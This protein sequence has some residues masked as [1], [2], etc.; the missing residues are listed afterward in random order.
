MEVKRQHI[1]FIIILFFILGCGGSDKPT[2]PEQ[3]SP[4]V[5]YTPGQHYGDVLGYID[6]L[7][8]NTP[9]IITVP[10]DGTL[11]PST[12][13]D[14]TYGTMARDLNAQ[15]IAERFAYFFVQRSGGLFPHII[16]SN[17]HRTKLDPN[18]DIT[19]GAQGDVG[20]IQAYNAYHSFIQTAIDSVEANFDSGLLLDLH[21][22]A[23]DIQRL[24]LGYLLTSDDLALSDIQI[25]SPTY[26]QKS[27]IS[28]IS[29]LSPTSFDEILR[30]ATS[31]GSLILS[32]SYSYS[33]PGGNSD[34]YTFDTVPSS[35]TK[36]P[37]TEPYFNGGYT[38]AKYSVGEINVIQIEA[39]Y[40][41]ARD[42]A[43]SYG[44]LA[45][46]LERS[47]YEFYREHTSVSIY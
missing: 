43:R 46:I 15:K 4:E 9:I 24:E 33:N 11:S 10:H 28:Q 41:R 19:E 7:A 44:A 20:A 14:R 47:V 26:E 2:T 32:K 39:H 25:G 23:H 16:V 3:V 5:K 13:A 40:D 37:G 42:T 6:Y 21:G 22:H 45:E 29:S 35:D 31:L 27:S 17:L 30:G 12:I 36:S 18:R 1:N 34:V 38:T 8:G